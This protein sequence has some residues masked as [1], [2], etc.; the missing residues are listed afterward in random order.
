MRL[1]GLSVKWLGRHAS[2]EPGGR[3]QRALT[4]PR[5]LGHKHEKCAK[6]AVSSETQL[7]ELAANRGVSDGVPAEQQTCT[8]GANVVGSAVHQDS[9]KQKFSSS[10]Q[11]RTLL[12][13]ETRSPKYMRLALEEHTLSLHARCTHAHS[14]GDVL[15]TGTERTT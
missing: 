3:V 11:N 10:A 7:I 5:Q 6:R 9:H 14:T 13:H 1:R 15:R 12:N 2:A 4:R 8:V